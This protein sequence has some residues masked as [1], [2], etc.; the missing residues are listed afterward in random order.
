[1]IHDLAGQPHEVDITYTLYFIP[2]SAPEAAGIKEIDTQWM[3]VQGIKPYPVFSAIKGS[4]TKGKFVYPDQA[5][6]PYPD[7]PTNPRNQW[8]VDHDATLVNTAGHLH[9]GGLWTDLNL[10]RDGKTVRL[11]RS[12]ANYYDP[13]GA[14]SCNV[15]M[16]ATAA[17]W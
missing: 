1:M 17:D 3:D 16:S 11:F 5:K 13:S 2:D 12:R 14:I 15:S 10:T 4:G 8:V 7:R 6:N 9:P